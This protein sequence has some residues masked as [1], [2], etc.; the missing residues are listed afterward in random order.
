M[1]GAGHRVDGKVAIVT[2]ASRGIGKAVA[3]ALA[4]AGADVTVIARTKDQVEQ[5]AEDISKMGRKALAIPMDVSREDLV[6]SAVKRTVS[7]LGRIDILSHNA[8]ILIFKPV[9]VIPGARFPGLDTADD[10]EAQTLAEWQRVMDVNLTSAFLLTQAVGPHM[11]KQKSGKVII[12]SSNGAE[13]GQSLQT[14]YN[15]S[16]AGLCMFIRCLAT[17][18]GAYNINV[19]AISPGVINT[20]MVAPLIS[21]PETMKTILEATPLGRVGEPEE[22]A[23]LALF[24]ASD[25]SNY[26]TGQTVTIDGGAIGRGPGV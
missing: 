22:V 15:T 20:E 12:M 17:E 18:W 26:I 24:L 2:G 23:M 7:E 14:A 8:A 21:D 11:L 3:L 25:A 6:Q 4:E 1:N 5:T 19:N 16:K 10:M 9:A 13:Q